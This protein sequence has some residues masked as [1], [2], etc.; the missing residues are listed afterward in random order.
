MRLVLTMSTGYM[1]NEKLL[2]YG[3]AGIQTLSHYEDEMY[4]GKKFCKN[5]KK[6]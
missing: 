4:L 1:K 3:R 6:R 5:K 2:P